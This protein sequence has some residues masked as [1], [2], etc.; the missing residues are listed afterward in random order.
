MQK[1]KTDD[2]KEDQLC[3]KLCD[4]TCMQIQTL[5]TRKSISTAQHAQ[6]TL[7]SVRAS[8]AHEL[9][10]RRR[11]I[12]N[13][14]RAI[15]GALEETYI[16]SAISE[17]LSTRARDTYAYKDHTPASLCMLLSQVALNNS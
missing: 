10:P 8:S 14:E 13:T 16:M 17:K 1:S 11:Q 3:I 6:H 5:M 7:H 2:K 15:L 9:Q 4:L 12:S